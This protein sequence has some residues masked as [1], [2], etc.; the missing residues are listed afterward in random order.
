MSSMQTRLKFQ[1]KKKPVTEV[2]KENV[3]KNRELG[4]NVQIER[5]SNNVG[6]KISQN[7]IHSPSKR[8][9][10]LEEEQITKISPPKRDRVSEDI[11]LSPSQRL[12]KLRLSDSYSTE[13]VTPEHLFANGSSYC[14]A[15]QAL[16]SSIPKAMP[17]REAEL[18]ELRKYLMEKMEN[19]SSGSLYVSGPPGTGK[20]ACL[21]S[22]LQDTAFESLK[23]VYVN[24]TSMKSSASIYARICEELNLNLRRKGEKDY[25]QTLEKFWSENKIMTLIMLDE[26]DQLESRKQSVLYRIFEW[27]S[28][29]NSKLVLIG[30][31]NALDLTDRILPRLQAHIKL[32]PILMHFPPYSKQQ[33]VHILTERLKEVDIVD[34]LSP[35]AIQLL[36]GKVASVSGDVRRALDIGRRVLEL[37]EARRLSQIDTS[38]PFS[39]TGNLP[40]LQ[41]KKIESVDINVVMDVLNSVHGT[42]LSLRNDSGNSESDSFPLQQKLLVCTFL[43]LLKQGKVKDI[44]VGKLHEVYRKV[45]KKRSLSALSQADFFSLCQLVETKGILQVQTGRETR[46]SKVRLVWDEDEVAAALQD[47]HLLAAILNDKSI[48]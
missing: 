17:G 40:C 1:C 26:M 39:E 45:C 14:A 23:R 9:S 12:C 35:T 10:L 3:P 19:S 11:S 34:I 20:T 48:V 22:I 15:R 37:A 25:I 32:R 6:L 2:F 5:T 30:I 27:P 24:C 28:K 16:H 38:Q 46:L 29:P 44:S 8:S 42:S 31:A 18:A 21:T 36:A 43:L 41:T 7:S 47:K 33:I 4:V 13:H